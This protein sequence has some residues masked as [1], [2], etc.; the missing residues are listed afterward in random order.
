MFRIDRN[1]V[2]YSGGDASRRVYTNVGD[3]AIHP[4]ASDGDETL[5]SVQEQAD[6]ILREAREKAGALVDQAELRANEV[7]AEAGERASRLLEEA[8]LR[9][10]AEAEKL[11][12]EARENGFEAGFSEGAARAAR[13][14][15]EKTEAE[16]A[17]IRGILDEIGSA[18]DAVIDSLEPELIDLVMEISQ[19][20]IN[21][22]L[23]KDDKIFVGIIRSA[24]SK[25]KREGKIIVRVSPEEYRRIFSSGMAELVVDSEMVRAHV[26]QELSFDRWDCMLESEG[27]TIN[28][29]VD[30]QLRRIALAFQIGGGDGA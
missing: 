10:G 21:V 6:G 11:R 28:S 16:I 15:A 7:L 2:S 26:E 27:E 22:Q 5:K 19:K 24:L 12:E 18:R 14:G 8:Q 29:G 9:A 20:V 4:V 30:S 13:E 23:E 25:L 17:E 1:F 3:S